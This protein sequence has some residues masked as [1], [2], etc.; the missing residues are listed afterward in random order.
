LE[1]VNIP[2]V[3]VISANAFRN[4]N[5]TNVVAP[6]VKYLGNFAFSENYNIEHVQLDSV[7]VLGEYCF[8]NT[9]NYLIDIYIPNV[10]IIC[11]GA[12]ANCVLI[13]SLDI[14]LVETI[15]AGAFYGCYS[16]TTA[17]FPKATT[18]D[19]KAFSSC[20]NLK[21]LYLTGSSLCTLVNSDAFTSTPIGGYSASAGT[22]GSIFVPASLVDAYKSATNWTY[23]SS[24][25]VGV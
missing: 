15:G 23:F 7:S 2:S 19:S 20:Y 5:L 10:E 8:Q 18:I 17:G 4:C 21:S 12:F 25:F 16:L 13:Q 24:R 3:E 11:E 6:S 22:Y 9:G 14:P 1:E